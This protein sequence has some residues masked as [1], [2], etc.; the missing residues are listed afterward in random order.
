MLELELSRFVFAVSVGGVFDWLGLI[1]IVMPCG[2]DLHCNS[3]QWNS[4]A[5]PVIHIG[6]V[7]GEHI[8][9]CAARTIGGDMHFHYAAC[10]TLPYPTVRIYH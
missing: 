6:K 10:P 8:S 3:L 9:F 2:A 7:V 4:I 5:D 1:R